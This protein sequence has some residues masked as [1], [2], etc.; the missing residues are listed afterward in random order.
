MAE[1]V[2]PAGTPAGEVPPDAGDVD[3]GVFVSPMPGTAGAGV[4]PS[5]VLAIGFPLVS[6][7]FLSSPFFIRKR[8]P[9]AITRT[10]APIPAMAAGERPFFGALAAPRRARSP[11]SPRS[12]RDPGRAA[13]AEAAAASFRRS[14]GTYCGPRLPAGPA[15]A[16]TER[17]GAACTAVGAAVPTDTTAPQAPH[18]NLVPTAMA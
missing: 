16:G 17:V 8:A 5:P 11:G 2:S 15:G 1:I 7:G 14:G 12:A 10:P 3:P 13:E 9:T 18:V 4:L 6:W